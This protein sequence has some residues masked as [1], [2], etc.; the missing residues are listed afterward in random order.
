MSNVYLD[1]STLTAIANQT[2]RLTET[3]TTYTPSQMATALGTVEKGIV[4]IGT[5]SVTE[6]GI[7]DVTNYASA[8]VN[9]GGIYLTDWKEIGFTTAPQHIIDSI[10]YSKGIMSTWDSTLTSIAAKYK[11]NVDLIYMPLVDTSNV[12]NMANTFAQC[13]KLKKVALLDTCNVTNMYWLFYMCS[14][15]EEIPSFDT[16]NVTSMERL[17]YMCSS[18]KYVPRLNTNKVTNMQWMFDSCYNLTNESLNNILGMC[19]DAISFSGTKTLRYLGIT[20][21]QA[22]TCMTLSN[23]NQFINSGWTTGYDS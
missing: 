14:N 7:V 22:Q 23:Y 10:N 5:I 15:L 2:R 6:N 12:T 18:L 17:C 8:N 20:S 21:T 4:P 3:Q 9:V 11:N 1:D 19:I 16:K 13:S